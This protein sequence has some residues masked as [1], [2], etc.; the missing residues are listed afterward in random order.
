MVATLT[1]PT[2][3]QNNGSISVSPGPSGY[4]YSWTGGLTGQNPMN[5]SPN[6]YTV[7]VTETA[8]GCT[9]TATVTLNPSSGLSS[10]TSK[11]DANCGQS[12]GSMTVEWSGGTGPYQI[13]GDLNQSNATSPHTFTNL[14][15]GSYVVTITDSNGCT[16][17]ANAAI[18]NGTGPVVSTSAQSAT[19]G[20]SNG[21]VTITWTSGVA[22][23]DILGDLVQSNATSPMIF[24]NLASGTYNITL[25]DANGC[26]SIASPSV[27]NTTGPQVSTTAIDATC[28]QSNGSVTVIWSG[29]TAPFTISGDLTQSNASSPTLFPNLAQGS[30]NLVVTDIN[31]CSM[32]TMVSVSNIAGPNVMVTQGNASCGLNN[33]EIEV[34]WIGGTGPFTIV[35]DINRSNAVSPAVFT[36]LAAGT[37]TFNLID[38]NNC[39][40]PHTVVITNTTSPTATATHTDANCGQSNGSMTVEWSGGTGPYQITG[41]LNQSNAT[42]PHTFTNLSS[43]SYV[44]TITD[45]N[46]CATTASAVIGNGTGPVV[47]ASAQSV[48]CGSSNGSVTITWTSGVAPFDI[49]GDLVQSNAT[50]PTIFTNLASGTYKITLT[51][52]NGCTSIAS[53][54]VNDP[55]G[56]LGSISKSDVTCEMDNGSVVISWSGGVGPFQLN[57]S[58]T[59]ANVS[60]PLEISDLSV[61]NYTFEIID[62]NGCSSIFNSIINSIPSVDIQCDALPESAQN[63]NDGIISLSILGGEKPYTASWTGISSGT[64]SGITS[65]TFIIN[66]LAQGVYSI[67][68]TDSNGCEVECES[69]VSSPDC[70]MTA[71][72]KGEVT[73]CFGS[74]DGVITLQITNPVGKVKIEWSNPLWNELTQILDAPAGSYKVTITDEANCVVTD[75][76][77]IGQPNQ[78]TINCNGDF[79][80]EHG[81][82]DGIAIVGIQGGTSNYSI[83]WSGSQSGVLTNVPIGNNSINDLPVGNYNITVVDNNGCTAECQFDIAD[84][85]CNLALSAIISQPSCYDICDGGVSLLVSGTSSN[86]DINWSDLSLNKDTEVNDLCAGSYSVTITDINGCSSSISQISLINPPKMEVEIIATSEVP[87][88]NEIVGL[89]FETTIPINLIDSLVW[90]NDDLSCKNCINPFITV[91]EDE[92]ISVILIDKNG[93]TA[94]DDIALRVRRLNIVDFPNIIATNSST[95]NDKFFPIGRKDNIKNVNSLSIYDRWGNLVF[96]KENVELND[97]DQGWDGT[98]RGQLVEQGVY[99][100]VAL[101]DFMDDTSEV[102]KGDVTVIR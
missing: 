56:I 94:I 59:K 35:G 89:S 16:T 45:S 58:I 83:Q 19:C 61:G 81:G 20:S 32:S 40:S 37:Y 84:V 68:I 36:I 78:L 65:N 33:G 88:V 25:T 101:V 3:G 51:D 63:A 90:M 100:F 48:T 75:N 14:S 5:V 93:C 73:K 97:P 70:M 71:D 44:V 42:S 2:C 99:I 49:S 66:D 98:F 85:P 1:Q 8:T 18:G 54:N 92:D 15:S 67:T 53:P 39:T 9:G 82:T 52:A 21:S 31:G 77:I 11:T 26:T 47:S 24:T 28:G 13:T 4:T 102:I 43:G 17:T 30:Y 12:N 41:D 87:F 80:S 79:V 23:F 55:G 91:R 95:R 60:S 29:G 38:D 69:T 22:P 86:Y 72:V 46:G 74:Y 62:S 10:S 34:S 96:Y 7:T 50:S 64:F 57:G 6:T 76:V 27:G